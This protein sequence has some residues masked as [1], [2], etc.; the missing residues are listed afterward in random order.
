MPE[1]NKPKRTKKASNPLVG[2]Q[3]QP[4]T[5]DSTTQLDIDTDKVLPDEIIATAWAV[6][7]AK[8]HPQKIRKMHNAILNALMEF[9]TINNLTED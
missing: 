5:L 9:Y 3:A 1:D 7:Y 8:Q 2:A 4:T 6:N